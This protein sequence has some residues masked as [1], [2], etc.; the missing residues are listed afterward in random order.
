MLS[1]EELASVQKPYDAA[2][3][4]GKVPNASIEERLAI[5][6]R[7]DYGEEHRFVL[8]SLRYE[9][10]HTSDIRLKEQIDAVLR[11]LEGAGSKGGAMSTKRS[12][13]KAGSSRR[14]PD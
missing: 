1:I 7:L 5:I 3:L 6:S 2:H 8:N 14:T 12:N 11:S 10:A 9:Y 4:L 13:S